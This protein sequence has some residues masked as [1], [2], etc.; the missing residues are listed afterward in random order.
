MPVVTAERRAK[1]GVVA[2]PFSDEAFQDVE[3]MARQQGKPVEQVI[4]E[5]LAM[6]R[7]VNEVQRQGG[8]V[9]AEKGTQ[10]APLKL[11]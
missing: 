11:K 10:R 1:G 5:S 6:N 9:F 4:L 8:K 2:V 7:W 3:E